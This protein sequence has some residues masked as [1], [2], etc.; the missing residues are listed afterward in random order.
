MNKMG[1][2]SETTSN[3]PNDDY[4]ELK[5]CCLTCTEDCDG[6]FPVFKTWAVHRSWIDP[7]VLELL[8]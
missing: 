2:Y 7:T 5:T 4:M 3:T 6:V 8:K 1:I